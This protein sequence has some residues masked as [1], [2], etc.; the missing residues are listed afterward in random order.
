MG[1]SL[2]P[3]P[4]TL[5]PGPL[6]GPA[7]R[8]WPWD[9]LPGVLVPGGSRGWGSREGLPSS[10]SRG[11]V[12]LYIP[13]NYGPPMAFWVKMGPLFGGHEQATN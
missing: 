12:Y 7:S 1:P 9:P 13:I 4:E 2:D 8:G 3:D 10:P 5:D 6:A 11:E